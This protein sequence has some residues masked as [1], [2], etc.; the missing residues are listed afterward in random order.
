[1]LYIY[2]AIFLSIALLLIF[3]LDSVLLFVINYVM[4][5]MSYNNGLLSIDNI[6]DLL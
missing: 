4:T 6:G 3:I 5:F 2:T 1:M